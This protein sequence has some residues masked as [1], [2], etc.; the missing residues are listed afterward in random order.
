MGPLGFWGREDKSNVNDKDGRN[1]G[2]KNSHT[3]PR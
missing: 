2:T 3:G 1:E